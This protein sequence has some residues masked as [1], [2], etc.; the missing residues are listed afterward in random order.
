MLTRSLQDRYLFRPRARLSPLRCQGIQCRVSCAGVPY[1]R[2]C[3]DPLVRVHVGHDI[4]HTMA[5]QDALAR[6]DCNVVPRFE[7]DR[8]VDLNVNIGN[9]HVAHLA[10]AQ[11]VDANDARRTK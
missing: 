1:G 6:N 9:D 4:E 5:R 3:I 7:G 11:V 10:R 2:I 8:G